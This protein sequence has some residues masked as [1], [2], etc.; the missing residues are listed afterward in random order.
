M[1]TVQIASKP[2]RRWRQFGLRTLGLLILLVAVSMALW[3][4]LLAEHFLVRWIERQQGTA[5]T[6]PALPDWLA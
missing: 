2:R 6:E 3:R 5:T 1:A 4:T